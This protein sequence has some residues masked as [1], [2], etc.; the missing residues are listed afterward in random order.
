MPRF[1]P[2]QYA[3]DSYDRAL[4]TALAKVQ[5]ALDLIQ[6]HYTMRMRATDEQMKSDIAKVSEYISDLRDFIDAP[7]NK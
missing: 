6:E 5:R 1:N 4:D 7:T 2:N 3:Q